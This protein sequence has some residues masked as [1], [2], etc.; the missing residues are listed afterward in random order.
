MAIPSKVSDK[1]FGFE[2]DRLDKLSL[3]KPWFKE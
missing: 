2:D 3:E 1:A